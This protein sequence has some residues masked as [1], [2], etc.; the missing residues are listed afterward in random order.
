MLRHED[1]GLS[2]SS[3]HRL[4][5]L[6]LARAA[7]ML[8]MLVE[9]TLQ[10]PTIEPKGVLWSAYGRSAPLFVLLAGVGLSLA[11]RSPDRPS[12]GRWW[13][14]GRRCCSWSGWRSP[15]R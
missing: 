5:G 14:P 11:T 13:P 7:A 3:A 10:Y 15:R 12:A 8:G 2:R 9:H 1:G 4:P 6:D